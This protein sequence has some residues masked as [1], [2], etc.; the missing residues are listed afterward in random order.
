MSTSYTNASANYICRNGNENC[1]C[2]ECCIYQEGNS[3]CQCD[4]CI[5]L[6]ENSYSEEQ[7]ERKE[8]YKKICEFFQL[9]S[10]YSSLE[11]TD[12]HNTDS[13]LYYKFVEK[14]EISADEISSLLKEYLNSIGRED[15]SLTKKIKI[16][17]LVQIMNLPNIRK[18]ITAHN[19]LFDV[20]SYKFKEFSKSNE[21][22]F[23][24]FLEQFNFCV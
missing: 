1:F 10:I 6:V 19:K 20:I 18:F 23:V 8:N 9:P 13:I 12:F 22:V 24:S 17:I 16:M 5:G 21:K 2:Q 3:Y 4:L 14:N 7:Q 11:I 15:S